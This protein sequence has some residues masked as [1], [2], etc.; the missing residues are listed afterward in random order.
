[1]DLL[2]KLLSA[3][4]KVLERPA[5]TVE[6]L[7]LS[8]ILGEPFVIKIQALTAPEIDEVNHGGDMDAG[9]V[10]TSTISPNFKSEDFRRKMTPASRKTPLTPI[11]AISHLF[12]AGELKQLASII[13]ELSGFGKNSINT[14]EELKKK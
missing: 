8:K 13:L 4:D 5:K 1:M 10:F 11:E 6:I 14:F 3:G 7:R 12:I 9:L 2:E